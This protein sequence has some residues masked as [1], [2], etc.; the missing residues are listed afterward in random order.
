GVV[1]LA[2]VDAAGEGFPLRWGELKDGAGWVFRVPYA[3]SAVGGEG[4]LHA[5]V[6]T[7]A[8]ARLAPVGEAAVVH[9]DCLPVSC[10]ISCATAARKSRLSEGSSAASK[11]RS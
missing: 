6:P 5:V 4:D 11:R 8:A 9:H 1:E 3:D 10:G 7:P 2:V